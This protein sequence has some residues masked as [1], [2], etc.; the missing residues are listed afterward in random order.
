MI[1]DARKSAAVDSAYGYIEA[2]E[3]N[4]SMN[5]INKD[6][7][8]LIEDGEDIDVLDIEDSINVK[9]TRPS[10][11]TV[12]ISKKKVEN[13]SLC[14][15]SYEIEYSSNKSNVIGTCSSNKLTVQKKSM[16]KRLQLEHE[17]G[18]TYISSDENIA[19]VDSNGLVIAKKSGK[20]KIIISKDN[21]PI[22][23]VAITVN[24][25]DAPLVFTKGTF[26]GKV[27]TEKVESSDKD[28]M[29]KLYEGLTDD[30]YTT[31]FITFTTYYYT[32]NMVNC[33]VYFTVKTPIT[34]SF[35]G[36]Y[37]NDSAGSSGNTAIISTVNDDN[38]E[39]VYIKFRTGNTKNYKTISF[40]P[41]NYVLRPEST[42]VFFSEWEIN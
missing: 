35:S 23:K 29:N 3:Y 8:P 12:T 6:K 5:M 33:Y 2:I 39:E 17:D 37:Y 26:G 10:S 36:S 25:D 40:E 20:V 16:Y 13:A 24:I 41:G 34:I 28:L 18:Y 1:N 14:I 32:Y 22:K 30:D 9:G 42:Y 38:S 4:N 11:G 15:N 21:V 31:N 27:S 7:Y 19:T